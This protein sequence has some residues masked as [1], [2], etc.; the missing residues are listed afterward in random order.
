MISGGFGT[1]PT[2]I[3]LNDLLNMLM[4]NVSLIGQ[5]FLSV[6]LSPSAFSICCFRWLKTHL[7]PDVMVLILTGYMT[8]LSR[9]HSASQLMW[10]EETMYLCSSWVWMLRSSENYLH[11]SILNCFQFRWGW[12]VGK[13]FAMRST[14]TLLCVWEKYVN[15][16]LGLIFLN[17]HFYR[18]LAREIVLGCQTLAVC[19]SVLYHKNSPSWNACCSIK[20]QFFFFSLSTIK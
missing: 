12:S 17:R 3:S 15:Y 10:V 7:I 6:K 14:T 18:R 11:V 19:R 4:E 8:G 9:A 20:K 2:D 5:E 16:I 1:L 13:R